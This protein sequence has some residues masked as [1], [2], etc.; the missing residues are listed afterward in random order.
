M[1]VIG[2]PQ[3]K[4]IH[5]HQECRIKFIVIPDNFLVL[6]SSAIGM[7]RCINPYAIGRVSQNKV[8]GL[9]RER[10]ENVPAITTENCYP[11]LAVIRLNHFATH[12][13]AAPTAP[14]SSFFI[15]SSSYT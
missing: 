13:I 3:N 6:D 12:T 4:F 9:I 7:D 2:S 8:K 14:A 10:R 1:I 15:R 11:V 5:S